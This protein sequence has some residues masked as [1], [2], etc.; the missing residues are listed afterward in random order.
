MPRKC[1]FLKSRGLP[2]VGC[3]QQA[4]VNF[5]QPVWERFPRSPREIL[6]SS[7]HPRLFHACPAV[8]LA[9]SSPVAV[10]GPAVPGASA[11]P[12]PAK[13]DTALTKD[14]CLEELLSCLVLLIP[15]ITAVTSIVTICGE[16]DTLVPFKC[17]DGSHLL[18][19][20]FSFAFQRFSKARWGVWKLKLWVSCQE[21]CSHS[22]VLL[23]TLFLTV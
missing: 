16:S 19:P 22:K 18:S 2:A 17:K 3:L 12:P 6:G 1:F 4:S 8:Q 11:R 23:E 20:F 5:S 7:G 10:P 21:L 13:L 14:N 15:G 9:A